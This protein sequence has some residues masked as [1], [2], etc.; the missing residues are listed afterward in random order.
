MQNTIG[1]L[2]VIQEQLQKLECEVV[3]EEGRSGGGGEGWREAR[4]CVERI[5]DVVAEV[6]QLERLH[7]YLTWLRHLQHL[8][9]DV[10]E[11]AR[12]TVV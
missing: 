4:G 9:Y 6:G 11:H 5:S 2:Q 8:R 10:C 7:N 12:H 1:Q 3:M